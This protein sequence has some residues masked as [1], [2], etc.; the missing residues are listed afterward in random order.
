MRQ[1]IKIYTRRIKTEEDWGDF[2]K[3]WYQKKKKMEKK[4]NEWHKEKHKKELQALP[5]GVGIGY[6][7]ITLYGPGKK[8]TGK[9]GKK[10]RDGRKRM[11]VDFGE[12]GKWWVPY[13]SLT[14]NKGFV[15]GDEKLA[16]E[17]NKV[18]NRAFFGK[19]D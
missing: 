10:I 7:G 1:K 8:L 12:I 17:M 5:E 14:T 13:E 2:W 3:E 6:N 16:S 9:W 19:K 18:L 4:Y 11:L 15:V